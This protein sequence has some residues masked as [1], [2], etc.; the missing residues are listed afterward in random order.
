MQTYDFQKKDFRILALGADE[1]ACGFM[2]IR[3]P[4]EYINKLDGFKAEILEGKKFEESELKR[5]INLT[6]VI[7][8][9]AG[10]QVS[11]REIRK[12]FPSK[13]MVFDFD[14]DLFGVLP[15]SE[16]YRDYGVQDISVDREDGAINLW[17]NGVDGFDKWK[18]RHK[19]LDIQEMLE[20]S[21]MVFAVT[22]RLGQYLSSR[23]NNRQVAVVPNFIDLA[24]YPDVE[25]TD[26]NKNG[27]F[28]FGFCGGMSHFGDI[29]IIK[30][31]LIKF[32]K[33]DKKRI[34][35]V[36]GQKFK[37]FEEV[38][39]QIRHQKWMPFEVNPMRMKMLDLDCLIAP[40]QD[41]PFNSRKDPL[42]FWDASG[43]SLP[44]VASNV[45]PFNDVIKDGENGLLFDNPKDFIKQ[46]KKL[47]KDRNLG[48]RIGSLAREQ[49]LK[50]D[51]KVRA[52]EIAKLYQSV[53]EAKR[54]KNLGK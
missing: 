47:E 28:R 30:D 10:S 17:K 3:K 14:D 21:D 20:E 24:L 42:K 27:E 51:I 2:R 25:I 43:L 16:H 53:W 4:F 32:L 44:L 15:S 49:V 45:A 31:E 34:F 5:I 36:V 50:R 19:L 12:A 33:K 29:N 52:E 1:G 38:E 40:L 41:F 39:D 48:K 23:A 22:E 54:Q 35:Y 18:N 13:P 8:F 46:L 6:D 26:P 37:G 11:A 7:M 9:K